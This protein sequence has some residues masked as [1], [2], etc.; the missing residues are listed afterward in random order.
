MLA[1]IACD[2][3]PDVVTLREDVRQDADTD[4]SRMHACTDVSSSSMSCSDQALRGML[5]SKCTHNATWRSYKLCQQSCY[6]TGNGY[7]GD[8]CSP[9]HPTPEMSECEEVSPAGSSCSEAAN[10]FTCASASW[11][12]K[13]YCGC[14]CLRLRP[15]IIF[16]LTDD[17]GFNDFVNAE[18]MGPT[19]KHTQRLAQSG[20]LINSTYTQPL[21]APTRMAFLSGRW[22]F[23]IQGGGEGL[24]GSW[25]GFS[26]TEEISLAWK[27]RLAGYKTYAVGKWHLGWASW[28]QLPSAR[29]FNRYFGSWNHGTHFSHCDHSDIFDLHY[30]E[31]E[32]WEHP[33]SSP[34]KPYHRFV[35]SETG[36]Y[37]AELFSRKVREFLIDHK[38]RF[39]SHPFFMYYP[40]LSV[41]SPKAAPTEC[42]WG[43]RGAR[44]Y[45][46][47]CRQHENKRR[48]LCAMIAAVD[49]AIHDLTSLLAELF[50]EENYIV[51]LTSDN[52]GDIQGGGSN[53]PLR[54]GKNS[55]K[56][57]GIRNLALVWGNS[58][59]LKQAAGTSFSGGA[60][61]LVDWHATITELAR[62]G[63]D[64]MPVSDRGTVGY[65]DGKSV[66]KAICT[67]SLLPM[68]RMFWSMGNT[69]AYIEGDYKIMI[70]VHSNW[71]LP[72]TLRNKNLKVVQTNL[73]NIKNDP[74]E[75]TDLS[76]SMP[77]KAREMISEL[78]RFFDSARYSEGSADLE[79]IPSKEDAKSVRQQMSQ[80]AFPEG[81]NHCGRKEALFPYYGFPKLP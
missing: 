36:V 9:P 3:G 64:A 31:S 80:V 39:P 60:M 13:G 21:C 4:D 48:D 15:H 26:R 69:K 66:W 73:F 79:G 62:L 65:S 78:Q 40:M 35:T 2:R 76:A 70:H 57:G 56:E 37:K 74:A 68:A 33:S 58:P 77:E 11:K 24:G 7:A 1:C 17:L 22:P 5:F 44:N 67:N 32:P 8:A 28:K 53:F 20:I 49:D 54:G 25:G 41:H 61:H 23:Q 42:P 50:H 46:D 51:I 6:E 16:I 30:E 52:G 45:Y 10:T 81:N 72:F 55:L 71:G 63:L 75:N 47:D 19:W 18:D 14:S 38:H 43:C 34:S 27:L 12:D 29:G 59:D